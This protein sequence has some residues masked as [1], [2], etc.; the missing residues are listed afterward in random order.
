[1]KNRFLLSV[2]SGL[3][4]SLLAPVRAAQAQD[5]PP[6]PVQLE[7][8]IW[9]NPG[10]PGNRRRGGGSRGGCFSGTPLTALAYGES[11]TVEELGVTHTDKLVG[12]LTSQVVPT[13]WFYL[14]TLLEQTATEF[15]VKD[16]GDQVIYQG[17]LMGETEAEGIVGVPL[18]V[19][20]PFG[21]AYRWFLTVDCDE[22]ERTTVNGWIASQDPG[23]DLTRTFAQADSRNR[24]AL[25][26][27][28]G[29]LHDALSELAV[30]RRQYP[31]DEAIARSWGQFLTSLD[32]GDLA[33]EP[34]LNCCQL[35]AIDIESEEAEPELEDAPEMEPSDD[36]EEM[37]PNAEMEMSE[38]EED[39]RTILQ[40]A[41]DRG[42]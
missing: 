11:T 40:R 16:A 25:Y 37:A 28:Y 20:L 27:N 15:V 9:R 5:L 13:L 30:L 42:N 34:V 14:P 29:Y 10:Q 6:L 18:G 36:L 1:M 22:S 17:Q 7:G 38:P 35:G 3:A 39:T 33:D 2:L 21:Q 26:T 23:T 12:A 8:R 41:R 32:L 19:R 24:V 4:L 31:E